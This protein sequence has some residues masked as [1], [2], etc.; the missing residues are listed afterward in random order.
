[1]ARQRIRTRTTRTVT[2]TTIRRKRTGGNKIRRV[3]NPRW[4]LEYKTH[5]NQAQNSR[6]PKEINI[7]ILIVWML[8]KSRG[9]TNSK[10]LLPW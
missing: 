3:R 1:M 2:R 8:I 10:T 5:F 4:Y 9:Q 7:L 6:N